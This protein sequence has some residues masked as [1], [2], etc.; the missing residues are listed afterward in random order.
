MIQEDKILH[1][2]AGLVIYSVFY[3]VN[4][5]LGLFASILAGVLKE[6]YDSYHP[7]QHTTDIMDATATIVGGLTAFL[8]LN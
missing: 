3:L 4:P 8:I 7:D 5:V 1:F 6:V 2:L